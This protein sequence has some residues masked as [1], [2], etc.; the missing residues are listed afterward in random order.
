MFSDNIV[1]NVVVDIAQRKKKLSE[2]INRIKDPAKIL[3]IENF[4]YK[5]ILHVQNI[6]D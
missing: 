2:Q 6:K 3:E 4:I 5:I 1:D